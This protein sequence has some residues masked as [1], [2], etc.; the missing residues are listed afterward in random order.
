MPTLYIVVPCYNEADCLPKTAPV[1]REELAQL[2]QA[3]KASP[4]SRILLVDD[5][6]A[7]GTWA[8]IQ[9]LHAADPAFCGLRLHPNRGHQNAVMAGLMEAMAR[10]DVTISIDADLQDDIHA[11]DAMMDKNAQGFPI[12]CGVRSS[13]ETDTFLKRFT[14]QSYYALMN[15]F[16]AKLIYNHADYRLLDR[17]AL[18]RLARYHGDDL[19][20][21]GLT[22]R[23]GL[24][25]AT[26]EYARALRVAGESKYTFKK[27]AKLALRGMTCARCKPQDTPRPPD[28]HIAQRLFS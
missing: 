1:F 16:G 15:L 18:E 13:R 2:T 23:L 28:P 3:G 4:D 11:M 8:Y 14:A 21:R 10:A 7:D 24:P 22:T 17:S 9:S 5:G 26:V 20:L 19:F 25:I 6:S 27:M 12:V